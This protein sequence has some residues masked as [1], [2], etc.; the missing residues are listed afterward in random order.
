MFERI[1]TVNRSVMDADQLA[2]FME[3]FSQIRGRRPKPMPLMPTLIAVGAG[4]AEAS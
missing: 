3:L 4:R 1:E 2:Y